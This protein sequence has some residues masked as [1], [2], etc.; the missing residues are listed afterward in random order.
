MAATAGFR[1]WETV[2]AAIL[3]FAKRLEGS[4]A[5]EGVGGQLGVIHKV[6]GGGGCYN[7]PFKCRGWLVAMVVLSCAHL[8]W[9]A[10]AITGTHPPTTGGGGVVCGQFR[11][12]NFVFQFGAKFSPRN[13]LRNLGN[14]L[15]F[16]PRQTS[17]FPSMLPL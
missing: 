14:F 15:L 11:G 12:E 7:T 16:V 6:R 4:W 3:A 9:A 2:S 17:C 8:R 5:A 1:G 13:F 10:I